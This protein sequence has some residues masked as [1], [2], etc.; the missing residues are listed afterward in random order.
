[1]LLVVV[2]PSRSGKVRILCRVTGGRSGSHGLAPSARVPCTVLRG[3]AL[4][5][6]VAGVV[7]ME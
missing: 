7:R 2:V 4:R 6:D 1:M 5:V 3:A